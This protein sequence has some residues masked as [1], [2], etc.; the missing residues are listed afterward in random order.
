MQ[1]CRA[2]AQKVPS[3]YDWSRYSSCMEDED[4]TAGF[5]SEGR[6]VENCCF[7]VVVDDFESIAA[8]NNTS[9]SSATTWNHVVAGAFTLLLP[10]LVSMGIM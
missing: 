4:C 6:C 1:R 8:D 7:E 9:K 5:Y 3:S 10:T 2:V